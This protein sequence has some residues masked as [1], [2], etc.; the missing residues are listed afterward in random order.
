VRVPLK[1]GVRPGGHSLVLV[2][3]VKAMLAGI[4]IWIFL[5]WLPLYFRDEFGMNLAAA[6][7]AGTFML[8]ISTVVGIGT[9]GWLS[10]CFATRELRN[11]ML[12][13]APRTW[14]PH[15]PSA[16]HGPAGTRTV[17]VAVSLFSLLRG[18][19]QSNENPTLCDVVPAELRSTAIGIMNTARRQPAGRACC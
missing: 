14:R 12:F 5:T 11:R 13:Q 8:Q 3:L 17:A 15:P 1:K 9:G 6:G 18:M 7:F 4:G 10:D 19:G 2:L 16:V